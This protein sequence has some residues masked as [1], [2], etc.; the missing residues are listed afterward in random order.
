MLKHLLEENDICLADALY[1][2]SHNEEKKKKH[3]EM[4]KKIKTMIK[5]VI[6]SFWNTL[7]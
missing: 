5:P 3:G 4:V 6:C 1:Q 7:P 2:E